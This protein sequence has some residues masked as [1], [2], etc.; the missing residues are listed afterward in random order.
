MVGFEGKEFVLFADETGSL[1]G[2]FDVMVEVDITGKQVYFLKLFDFV[3]Q[4]TFF[5][6]LVEQLQLFLLQFFINLHIPIF[7]WCWEIVSIILLQYH[8]F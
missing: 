5:L 7:D 8:H 6:F 3:L 2:F 1:E 4:F